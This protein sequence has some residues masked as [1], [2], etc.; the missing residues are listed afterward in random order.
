MMKKVH[1]VYVN[2]YVEKKRV[3]KHVYYKQL[4]HYTK[5]SLVT[6]EVGLILIVTCISKISTTKC[7]MCVMRL[8]GKKFYFRIA[9]KKKRLGEF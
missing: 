3:N 4:L 8:I 7:I 5:I 2:T 6:K 9:V 1:N